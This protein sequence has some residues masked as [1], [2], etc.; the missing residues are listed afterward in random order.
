[1]AKNTFQFLDVGRFDP[2]KQEAS[3]RVKGFGEIYGQFDEKSSAEQSDRCIECG[4]P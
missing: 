1:M 2:K 3:E 4:N